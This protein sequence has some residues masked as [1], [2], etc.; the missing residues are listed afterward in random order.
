[1]QTITLTARRG[2]IERLA[3]QVKLDGQ[4]PP[5]HMNWGMG[6]RTE[7]VS[8]IEAQMGPRYIPLEKN[9]HYTVWIWVAARTTEDNQR[10]IYNVEGSLPVNLKAAKV[11]FINFDIYFIPVESKPCKLKLN[12]KSWDE[13]NLTFRD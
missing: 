10:L 5:M 4:E 1:M 13:L 11:P 2:S 7:G 6:Q 8:S 9:D 3:M 12:V